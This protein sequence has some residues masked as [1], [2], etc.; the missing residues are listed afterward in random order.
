MAKIQKSDNKCFEDVKK[1]NTLIYCCWEHKT[2]QPLWKTICQFLKMLNIELLYD[3][4]IPL[5]DIC[6]R[7]LTIDIHT[8]SYTQT[9][10]AVS[11]IRVRK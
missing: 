4:A 9:F 6:P 11:F 10:T 2:E 3:L 8:K 5:L 1:I 7:D